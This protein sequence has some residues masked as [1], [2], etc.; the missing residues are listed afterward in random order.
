M[1]S[2]E[3]N[4][5]YD[6][7]GDEKHILTGH[8]KSIP[9]SSQKHPKYLHYL[10]NGRRENNE[11]RIGFKKNVTEEGGS[12]T[13]DLDKIKSLLFAKSSQERDG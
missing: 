12:F 9:C 13:K 7:K 10:E 1:E 8:F 2:R 3:E 6:Q 4:L 5:L 11:C